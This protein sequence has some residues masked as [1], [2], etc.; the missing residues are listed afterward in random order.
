MGTSNLFWI[1][2]IWTDPDPLGIQ[3]LYVVYMYLNYWFKPEK[4]WH[5]PQKKIKY[6]FRSKYL[7]SER[8]M[9][10]RNRSVPDLKIECLSLLS[11][12]L[13]LLLLLELKKSR[14][15][16]YNSK[17]S[18]ISLEHEVFYWLLFVYFKLPNQHFKEAK[19]WILINS[20]VW[21]WVLYYRMG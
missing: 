17:Q 2:N 21:K 16:W 3:K 6:L 11:F 13:L 5:E 8:S 19:Q 4:N 7:K 10:E 14:I 18:N 15:V 9:L 12:L 1:L 20:T